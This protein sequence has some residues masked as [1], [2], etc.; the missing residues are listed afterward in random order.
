MADAMV[1]LSHLS[2]TVQFMT[3]GLDMAQ[4]CFFGHVFIDVKGS[5]VFKWCCCLGC[6]GE[7]WTVRSSSGMMSGSRL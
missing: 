6:F 1:K 5:C 3:M 4:F 2:A 7:G